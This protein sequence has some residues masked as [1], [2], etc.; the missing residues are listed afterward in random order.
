MECPGRLGIY[1]EDR[2]VRTVEKPYV[3]LTRKTGLRA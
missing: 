3:A 2:Q 1:G